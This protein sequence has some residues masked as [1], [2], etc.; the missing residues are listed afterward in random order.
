MAQKL[1]EID[2]QFVIFT[3]AEGTYGIDISKVREIITLQTITKVP[4]TT[5]VIEGIINLRGYVIPIF[6]VR[7]KFNLQE[8][9]QSNNTRIMVVDVKENTL[10]IIVDGVSEVLRIPVELIESPSTMLSANISADFIQ[11]VAKLTDK[12]VIILNLEKLLG[13][14]EKIQLDLIS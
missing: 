1:R 12:M 7:K 10:G 8:L 14:D 5:G 4:G 9:E 2:S 3:L 13:K 6:D 11:G